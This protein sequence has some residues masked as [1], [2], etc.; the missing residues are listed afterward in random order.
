MLIPLPDGRILMLRSRFR[1]SAEQGNSSTL[2]PTMHSETFS[3]PLGKKVQ[4]SHFS[5][6]LCPHTQSQPGNYHPD[7][8]T[9]LNSPRC[10]DFEPLSVPSC[11]LLQVFQY[12]HQSQLSL[13]QFFIPKSPAGPLI[14]GISRPI[15]TVF[16]PLLWSLIQF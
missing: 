14:S 12:F 5:Q 7:I 8:Y 10:P 13:C 16:L 15:Y 3:L 1:A 11:S 6:S 9:S 2:M 4:F